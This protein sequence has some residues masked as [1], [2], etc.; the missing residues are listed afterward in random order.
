VAEPNWLKNRLYLANVTTP[1]NALSLGGRDLVVSR[2]GRHRLEYAV[3]SDERM[4]ERRR[5]MQQDQGKE[6]ESKVEV[7]VPEQRMQAVALR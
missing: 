5:D 6:H 4:E 1:Q 3:T 2:H 7:R